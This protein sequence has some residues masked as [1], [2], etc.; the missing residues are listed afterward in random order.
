MRQR[1]RRGGNHLSTLLGVEHPII[2]A[3][4]AGDPSTPALVAAVSNAGGLGSLAGAYLSPDQIRAA[5][6]DVRRRTN[7]PFA[8]NLFA[9]GAT[10]GA[11]D[12]SAMLALLTR[13]HDA[14]G[15]APPELPSVPANR[16]AEQ[17]EAVL[18]EGVPIFSFTFGI[19]D[20]AALA[21]VR[22]RGVVI[23]GTATTATEATML[24]TAGA[25]VV[26]VQGSEAGAHRGTFAAPFEAAMI[27]TMALVPLVVDSVSVP[28]VASG[29]IMDG[30]GIVAAQ[31]LGA[32]GVQMGTAFLLTEE[33]GTTNAYRAS[34]LAAGEDE[35]VLTRAF[36]GRP[37]R[38]IRNAFIEDVEREAV[39]IPAFPLQN[40]LTRPL[41]TA[42]AAQGRSEGLSLWA[43]QG[44]RLAR[45]A[46]AA[47]LV[48]QLV[49]EAAAVREEIGSST[50]EW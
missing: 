17:L 40:A 20:S 32:A 26:V 25:D 35:T 43:G 18:T 28:V 24:E 23:M 50:G 27:G 4:M 46:P 12:H 16:F 14:L 37:A 45:S 38:G 7:R 48:A 41:R 33:A 34:L 6:A 30:R 49:A 1:Q 29:G 31:A 10:Q 19:P 13:W 22:R 11:Q 44:L 5:V 2:L 36:S 21:E 8:V 9:G 42:A 3:P 15:I 39:P 47:Q